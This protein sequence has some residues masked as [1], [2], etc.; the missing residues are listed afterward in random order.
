MRNWKCATM[1]ISPFVARFRGF[2]L[3]GCRQQTCEK[4]AV[5]AGRTHRNIEERF[6]SRL[7]LVSRMTSQQTD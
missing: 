3:V 7:L 2:G 6:S 5:N 4:E 1:D